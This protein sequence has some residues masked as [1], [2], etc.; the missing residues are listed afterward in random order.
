M[1]RPLALGSDDTPTEPIKLPKYLRSIKENLLILT[2]ED[3]DV[4]DFRLLYLDINE[5]RCLSLS[6]ETLH[7]DEAQIV[8]DSG[9]STRFLIK[10]QIGYNLA[11]KMGRILEQ[12]S[13]LFV[14]I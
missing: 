12:V 10:F 14:N 11:L 5:C 3:A 4:Y 7:C 8:V 6:T 9:D 1:F 13:V 2:E